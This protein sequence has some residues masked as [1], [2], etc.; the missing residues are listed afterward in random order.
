[1]ELKSLKI[2]DYIVN[3]E[4]SGKF[5]PIVFRWKFVQN[6]TIKNVSEKFSSKIL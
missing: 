3:I 1:M 6:V 4:Y 5:K 2:Q